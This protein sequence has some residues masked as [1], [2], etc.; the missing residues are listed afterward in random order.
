[1]KD[2]ITYFLNTSERLSDIS[3]WKTNAIIQLMDFAK[4]IKSI[5]LVQ[6]GRILIMA[7][8]SGFLKI[9]EIEPAK[10]LMNLTMEEKK[11]IHSILIEEIS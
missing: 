6:E 7:L 5:E 9:S 1:M 10:D 8:F 4:R 3:L 2:I 11:D